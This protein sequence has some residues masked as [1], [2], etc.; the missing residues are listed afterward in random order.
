MSSDV[1][2]A[3]SKIQGVGLF[4]GRN[5]SKGD[6]ICLVFDLMQ[7]DKRDPNSFITREG[8]KVN[9]QLKSNSITATKDGTQWYLVAERPI[10]RGEEITANYHNTP[11]FIKKDTRGYV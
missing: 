4:A 9:H 8:R 5:F 7:Y 11:S 6:I 1:Y 3:P 2:I 10:R